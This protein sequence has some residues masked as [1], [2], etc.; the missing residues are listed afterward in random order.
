MTSEDTTAFVRI[1][2]PDAQP[3]PGDVVHA[4]PCQLAP[5]AAPDNSV[6]YSRGKLTYTIGEADRGREEQIQSYRIGAG[7]IIDKRSTFMG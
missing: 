3:P 5:R 2:L 7:K 1:W 4:G 6:K